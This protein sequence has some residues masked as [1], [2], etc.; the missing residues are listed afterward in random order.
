MLLPL[1]VSADSSIIKVEHSLYGYTGYTGN[2]INVSSMP[3]ELEIYLTPLE[4]EHDYN[5]VLGHNY[6]WYSSYN[7]S[8]VFV[9]ADNNT[10]VPFSYILYLNGEVIDTA[11]AHYN[12]SNDSYS[13]VFEQNFCSTTSNSSL[14]RGLD[15]FIRLTYAYTSGVPTANSFN[16]TYT[17]YMS[18]FRDFVRNNSVGAYAG[19]YSTGL[20]ADNKLTLSGSPS[21]PPYEYSSELGYVTNVRY[22]TS[23]ILND[24]EPYSVLDVV[25]G[26]YTSKGV[27][28]ANPN[29]NYKIEYRIAEIGS[30]DIAMSIKNI[31]ILDPSE[32]LS[33]N[34]NLLRNRYNL[35]VTPTSLHNGVRYYG[36]TYIIPNISNTAIGS[37]VLDIS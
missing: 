19:F 1:S 6:R 3:Y 14:F 37:V 8:R 23:R 15:G 25:C 20:T 4:G 30:E 35:L 26:R 33:Y 27:D 36:D 9:L 13:A 10:Y 16:W 7:N 12:S 21:V 5:I 22:N 17:G 34:Y 18:A 2:Y 28:L 32:G 29:G 31:N 11:D 24:N